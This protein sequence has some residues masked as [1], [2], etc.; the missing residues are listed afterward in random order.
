MCGLGNTI[1]EQGIEQGGM[2][3]V[4]FSCEIWIIEY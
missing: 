2:K 4:S 1:Y 3:N